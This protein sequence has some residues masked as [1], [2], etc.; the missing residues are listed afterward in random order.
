MSEPK[1]FTL[2]EPEGGWW[3]R[4]IDRMVLGPALRAVWNDGF[5]RGRALGFEE[6][7]L[8]GVKE[9]RQIIGQYR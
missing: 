1:P 2:R 6:G 5:A 4:F 3:A 9:A 8:A 7:R